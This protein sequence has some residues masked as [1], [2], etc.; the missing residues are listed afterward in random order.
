MLAYTGYWTYSRALE[1]A[2][3]RAEQARAER[4]K[5]RSL[6]RWERLVKDLEHIEGRIRMRSLLML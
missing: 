4:R 3:M 6:G 5:H 1:D 2:R